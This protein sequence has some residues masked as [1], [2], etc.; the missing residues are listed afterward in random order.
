MRAS[1]LRWGL[2]LAAMLGV[3]AW[4]SAQDS[5]VGAVPPPANPPA[6]E[7]PSFAVPSAADTATAGLWSVFRPRMSV[8]Y[9][10]G[11]GFGYQYGYTTLDALWPIIGNNPNRLLYVDTRALLSDDRLL[12]GNNVELGYRR[13]NP[14][15]DR[16]NGIWSSWDLRNTPAAT[17]NQVSG[18]LE[19]YGRYVDGH[20]NFYAV[21]NPQ[22]TPTGTFIN[23][24]QPT[25]S[26]HNILL[27]T[28]QNYE[29]ALSGGDMEVGGRLPGIGRYGFRGYV[30]G[31][32]YHADSYGGVGGGQA[33]L[34]AR[35]SNNFD[36]NLIVRNDN[37]F[38]TT[39]AFGGAIRWGG[40][41]RS[42]RDPERDSVFNRM[43]DPTQRNVNVSVLEKTKVFNQ[44]AINPAT[45]QPIYI[46]FVNNTAP[47]GGDG[48]FLRP[49]NT[50]APAS[51]LAGTNGYIALEP[52]N[53][54][55]SGQNAGITL[56]NGQHLLG[57]GVPNPIMAVQG[58]FLLPQIG[59]GTP[60][61]TNTAGAGITLASNNEVA[62]L[63]IIGMGGTTQGIIGTGINGFNIH[64]VNITGNGAL[65]SDGIQLNNA[66]GFGQISNTTVNFAG[67]EGL[68]ISM[69]TGTLAVNVTNSS[70]NNNST[71]GITLTT[72][73]TANLA[74][75]VQGGSQTGNGASGINATSSGTSSLSLN[76]SNDVINGNGVDG[77]T[78]NASNSSTMTASI[79][80][81]TIS[82]NAGSG[83]NVTSAN[84]ATVSVN[85]SGSTISNNPGG[86]ITWV[87]SSS[88]AQVLAANANSIINNTG[89]SGIT[90]AQL[91]T[92]AVNATIT[93]NTMTGNTGLVGV[94][95]SSA[96]PLTANIS[97]NTISGA[98]ASSINSFSASAA[99]V[100]AN[101]NVSGGMNGIS[102]FTLGGTSTG[103]VTGNTM[104]GETF[105]GFSNTNVGGTL[106]LTMSNNNSAPAGAAFGYS[107]INVGGAETV[108]FFSNGGGN[109]LYQGL[110][111]PNA[112]PA[113]VNLGATIN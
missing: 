5:R 100:I 77:V 81:S 83:I 36:M 58:T 28:V 33:R 27:P 54:T 88:A 47:P 9:N 55:T 70:F 105:S 35:V 22:Y 49:L 19:S 40:V 68:N 60:V 13:Y 18:G 94:S 4:V 32:A 91:G 20:A 56:L 104:T 66:S 50:L 1:S 14:D 110:P 107:F 74:V 109:N 113:I 31:Y 62:N 108:N 38:G 43:E 72:A 84:A 37:A 44:F 87:S 111:A 61:I 57:T 97:G 96:G 63:N 26:G 106:T 101:N 92:G 16:I 103:T 80:N 65:A 2:S 12:W 102:I 48:S 85:A 41:R 53:L 90:M 79:Q 17:Y 8:G 51:G 71:D 52:G 69:S 3:S 21:T 95:L 10:T 98:T 6:Y 67:G 29:S 34:L 89:A 78:L 73:G 24:S 93:N 46:I 82:G 25:I 42:L 39:V 76:A 15:R 30:G 112:P 11:P 45:G 86:G 75:A 99:L 59:T 7:A 64:G 23:L